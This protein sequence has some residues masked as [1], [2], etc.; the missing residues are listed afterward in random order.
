[1]IDWGYFGNY[2]VQINV[3]ELV[4]TLILLFFIGWPI[5]IM[6]ANIINKATHKEETE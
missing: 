6:L 4:I 3:Y 5:L 1:M 2:L